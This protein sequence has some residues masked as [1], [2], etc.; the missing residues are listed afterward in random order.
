[1]QLVG[2]VSAQTSIRVATFN[3]SMEADNYRASE[4]SQNQNDPTLLFKHLA[5]GDNQQIK[6]IAQIIQR[7]RPDIILLNEFDYSSDPSLGP[8]AFIKNYLNVSQQGQASIDYPYFYYGPVNTGVASGV[9]LNNDGK[10]ENSGGD[11]FGYGRY[12][13]Q[14]GMLLLSRYPIHMQDVRTFQTFLW[15]DMP[16]N[17]LSKIK[18]T[19]GSAWYSAEAMEVLRLS[20]KSHWDI[21]VDVDGKIVHV[22]A[23]HPTPPVFDG[24]ENRNGFRNHDEIQFWNDY[25]SS[26]EQA[27]YIYDDKGDIGG[28]SGERF[29]ILGDLNA[30][31]DAGDGQRTMMADLLAHPLVSQLSLPTSL[32]GKES[33]P[34][35]PNAQYHT[36]AWGLGVDYV[37]TS[38]AGFSSLD[39]GVFWP[40]ENE[41]GKELV[42]DR[43]S[44]SDHRMV[45]R[46]LSLR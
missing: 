25:L 40:G 24:P 14:Y 45:W 38:K 13:G 16:D 17:S 37:I 31:P 8:E 1:M 5:T 43:K 20:S 3:V 39:A 7:V 9:D 32:G 26:G 46:E 33:K 15:K 35:D 22:L 29:V 36:A 30:S 11:A 34:D 12:A 18:N 44:S 4:A 27:N 10:L 41:S 42:A 23:S 2:C 6:N 19:D 21:P 28:F